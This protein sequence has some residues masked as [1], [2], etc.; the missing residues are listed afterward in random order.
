MPR[1]GQAAVAGGVM[2]GWRGD[3]LLLR[4][5]QQRA[6]LLS[7]FKPAGKLHKRHYTVTLPRSLR[8][9]TARTHHARTRTHSHARTR[10][11]THARTDARTHA[12]ARTHTQHQTQCRPANACAQNGAP[13]GRT[14]ARTTAP[15]QRARKAKAATPMPAAPRG[16]TSCPAAGAPPAPASLPRAAPPPPRGASR[17]PAAWAGWRCAAAAGAPPAGAWTWFLIS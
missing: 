11:H 9:Q 15:R 13:S 2:Q 16:R 1:E 14:R 10:T 7:R 6:C 5:Q 4:P 3:F 17:R 12:L 8:R